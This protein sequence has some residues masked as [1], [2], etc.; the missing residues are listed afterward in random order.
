MCQ[1]LSYCHHTGSSPLPLLTV[2][3]ILPGALRNR[4][5]LVARLCR[6][7]TQGSGPCL[8]LM[9]IIRRNTDAIHRTLSCVDDVHRN[10]LRRRSIGDFASQP[11]AVAQCAMTLS[12]GLTERLERAGR[13][14]GMCC[15]AHL[16]QPSHLA[17][18]TFPR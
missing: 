8:L 17:A 15:P 1:E 9:A 3:L 13:P 14:N 18:F 4:I 7:G 5:K 16:S 2:G 12:A 6:L 10:V 11:G